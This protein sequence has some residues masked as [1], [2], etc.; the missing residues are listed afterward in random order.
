MR[1][2]KIVCTIG[3]ASSCP[4]IL[5]RLV[6]EGMDVARLN[7]SHGT[8]E[9]HA[10]NI[11]TIREIAKRLGKPV[12]ILQD[13]SGP[14]LRIGEMAGEVTLVPGQPFTLTT[15]DIVGNER[16]ASVPIEDLPASLSPGNRLFLND[17]IIEL[18]V[19]ETTETEIRCVVRSGG[20]LSSHKG[21]NVPDV[22]INID[23]I[24]PKDLEDLDFGIDH[25]VD[26]VAASFIRRAEDLARLRER[27]AVRGVQIPILA[28]IEKH[29]AV[30]NLDAILNAADGAMV[31]RGD[32]GIEVSIDEVPIIQKRIIARCNALAKPVITA[33]EMLDSMHD[34]PR[35]TRAEVTDVANAIF[36]GTD[37]L[38]LSRETATGRFPVETVQMMHRIAVRTEESERYQ[39]AL[40]TREDTVAQNVTDAIGEAIRTMAQDL[41]VAAVVPATASG[42]TARMVAKY[43]PICPI[44]AVSHLPET[45]Q[46]L[47][48]TWGVQPVL[49]SPVGTTDEMLREA[50]TVSLATGLV[51]RGDLILISAGVPIGTPGHTNLIKVERV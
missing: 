34:R 39:R 10:Q 47:A 13:L 14:K 3:P 23:P 49:S 48:L 42:Y 45:V 19:A 40:H 7:F 17:G 24:T 8:H 2:T 25:G 5:E 30:K 31:A 36:D 38:M 20:R 16:C 51:K 18:T 28:K 22:S 32:L 11:R 6:R 46:R 26:W 9:E 50:V 4:D 12:A 41:K 1:R 44:I 29:E 35:P 21:L 15:R 27:M 33:T 37:C 43:R